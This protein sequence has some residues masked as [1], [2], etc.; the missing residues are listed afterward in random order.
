MRPLLIS[1]PGTTT[2]QLHH[3]KLLFLLNIYNKKLFNKWNFSA[4]SSRFLLLI[5]FHFSPIPFG[6]FFFYFNTSS[7]AKIFHYYIDYWQSLHIY[8]SFNFLK[9]FFYPIFFKMQFFLF[10]S[11]L[12]LQLISNIR[13]TSSKNIIRMKKIRSLNFEF[14]LK[15]P[16]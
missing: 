3:T 11:L 6:G 15:N 5:F 4:F 9:L 13:F 16:A 12:S 7:D 14:P 1:I 2:W 10:F 8:K